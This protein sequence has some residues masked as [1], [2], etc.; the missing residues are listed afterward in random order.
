MIGKTNKDCK[1]LPEVQSDFDTW[2]NLGI[3]Y[4]CRKVAVVRL[5]GVRE[6]VNQNLVY[7]IYLKIK[8]F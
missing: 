7:I 4:A 3:P 5:G 1:N 8:S 6:I 2:S